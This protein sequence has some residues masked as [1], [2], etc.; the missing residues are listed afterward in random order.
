MIANQSLL[1]EYF[2]ILAAGA[3]VVVER[4]DSNIQHRMLVFLAFNTQEQETFCYS[5]LI[6]P[7]LSLFCQIRSPHASIKTGVP[8][9]LKGAVFGILDLIF[10]K[11]FGKERDQVE[12]QSEKKVEK[13]SLRP[14]HVGILHFHIKRGF[15]FSVFAYS[16]SFLILFQLGIF[17]F[18]CNRG[19]KTPWVSIPPFI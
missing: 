15:S 7:N 9:P 4:Q 18:S 3:R 11:E 10:Q 13:A 2:F 19:D 1:G 16:I 8:P 6:L 17:I 5:C 14:R 12:S